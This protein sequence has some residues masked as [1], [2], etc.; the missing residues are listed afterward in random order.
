MWPILVKRSQAQDFLAFVTFTFVVRGHR[1]QRS[2][3]I[4]SLINCFAVGLGHATNGSFS[5]RVGRNRRGGTN[6]DKGSKQARDQCHIAA[7][8]GNAIRRECQN[9][10]TCTQNNP[11]I[12]KLGKLGLGKLLQQSLY[13]YIY[14]YTHIHTYTH[15][16]TRT[17][18]ALR[19]R[20][21]HILAVQQI[22]MG[23]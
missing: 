13:I 7:R 23:H 18:R 9:R 10:T 19:A 15:I 5:A 1:L 4:G 12:G 20:F 22:S 2:G 21:V 6:C 3:H 14:I 16:Y 17:Q 8:D 11:R